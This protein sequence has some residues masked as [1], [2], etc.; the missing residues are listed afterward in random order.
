MDTGRISFRCTT[1][2]TPVIFFISEKFPCGEFEKT[3]KAVFLLPPCGPNSTGH[4]FPSLAGLVNLHSR[5]RSLGHVLM[6]QLQV[7]YAGR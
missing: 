4:P 7:V 5:V 1:V 2:G 3:E 6:E